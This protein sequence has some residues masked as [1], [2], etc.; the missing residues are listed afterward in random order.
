MAT[1]KDINAFLKRNNLTE[2]QVTALWNDLA[3]TNS[4]L[5]YFIQQGVSWKSQNM[6]VIEQIP[7][8]KEKDVARLEN[9][10]KEE[11]EAEKASVIKAEQEKYYHDNF[12]ELMANKIDNKEALTEEELET[13]VYLHSY[14]VEW[15]ENRRWSRSVSSL[16]EHGDRFFITVW[17]EGLTESQ[18][19]YFSD[20]PY[21]VEKIE[22]TT[23]VVDYKK[24]EKE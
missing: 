24:I 23:V 3:P 1:K 18:G 13:F 9:K 8:L 15:G 10:K 2:D 12:L 5:A 17:E 19:N 6:Y 14:E 22:H 4:T 16:C 7:T 21:E 20:Q 11:E